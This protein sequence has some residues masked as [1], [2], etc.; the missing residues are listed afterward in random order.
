LQN[1]STGNELGGDLE[2]GGLDDNA[3]LFNTDRK[4]V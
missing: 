4:G 1:E 3:K 2:S